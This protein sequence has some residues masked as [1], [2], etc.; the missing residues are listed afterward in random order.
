VMGVVIAGGDVRPGDPVRV[1]LP[2]GPHHPL[3]PV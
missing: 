3:Q 2:D 1:E